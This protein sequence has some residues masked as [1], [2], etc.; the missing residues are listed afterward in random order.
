MVPVIKSDPDKLEETIKLRSKDAV[1]LLSRLFITVPSKSSQ[2]NEFIGIGSSIC[3]FLQY[4]IYLLKKKMD[5]GVGTKK[6]RY[7]Y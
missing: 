7:Y 6:F 4:H 5:T 3:M 2:L 1:T